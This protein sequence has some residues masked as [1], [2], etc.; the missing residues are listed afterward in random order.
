VQSLFYGGA[1]VIAVALSQ[2][3]RKRK[4]LDTGN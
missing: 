2:L 1:L 3:A 4:A